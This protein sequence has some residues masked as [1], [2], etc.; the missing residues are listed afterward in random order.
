MEV[1]SQCMFHSFLLTPVKKTFPA[2]IRK[3]KNTFFLL[4]LSNSNLFP[5]NYMYQQAWIRAETHYK[6]RTWNWVKRLSQSFCSGTQGGGGEE[7][8]G[9]CGAKDDR[10]SGGDEA[11]KWLVLPSTSPWSGSL[12]SS[13]TSQH[14]KAKLLFLDSLVHEGRNIQEWLQATALSAPFSETPSIFWFSLGCKKKKHH[15][16]NAAH[17]GLDCWF[18]F[19]CIVEVYV[20]YVK[21]ANVEWQGFFF[22]FFYSFTV[23]DS[24]F[25]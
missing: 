17:L 5:C 20:L 2:L 24:S 3:K 21:K 22:F 18:C 1:L 23:K 9:C 25:G 7:G 8:E 10:L 4:Q 13:E 15:R 16:E 11:P 19:C 14:Q 6:I 12:D